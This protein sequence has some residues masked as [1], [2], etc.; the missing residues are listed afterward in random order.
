MHNRPHT[1]AAKAETRRRV[2]ALLRR[3]TPSKEV[4]E[5]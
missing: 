2:H 1:D 5:L 4:I 3:R